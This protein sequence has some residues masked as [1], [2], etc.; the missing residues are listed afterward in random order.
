MEGFGK[1]A[2]L[3]HLLIG[4]GVSYPL[5]KR[6]CMAGVRFFGAGAIWGLTV[7]YHISTFITCHGHVMPLGKDTTI[8]PISYRTFKDFAFC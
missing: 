5:A 8:D 3:N 2:F 6:G 7:G 1:V 4:H